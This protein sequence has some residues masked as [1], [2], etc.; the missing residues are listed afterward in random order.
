[1]AADKHPLILIFSLLRTPSSSLV[2]DI[3]RVHLIAS[4]CMRQIA[5]RLTEDTL[6]RIDLARGDVPRERWIRRALEQ[7]LSGGGAT[8]RSAV[9]PDRPVA[10]PARASGHDP[11]RNFR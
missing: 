10:T 7:A 11:F 5:L 3:C 2:A 6:G 1:M 4:W 8:E 9:A